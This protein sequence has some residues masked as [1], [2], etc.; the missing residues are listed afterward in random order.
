MKY[1]NDYSLPEALV[2]FVTD[3]EYSIGEADY[4]FSTVNSPPQ[5]RRLISIHNDEI[6]VDVS[7]NLWMLFGTAVH[8]LL[9]DADKKAM[10]DK[11]EINDDLKTLADF[12]T[13]KKQ[14]RLLEQRMYMSVGGVVISGQTDKY[15]PMLQ[16]IDDYKTTSVYKVMMDDKDDWE[17][18]MNVYTLLLEHNGHPVKEANIQAFLKDWKAYDYAKDKSG[19]YPPIPFKKETFKLWDRLDTLEFLIKRIRLHQSVEGIIDAKELYEKAPCTP[20]DR[21][22]N[23]PTEYRVFKDGATRATNNGVFTMKTGAKEA[24]DA[25]LTTKGAGYHI[26]KKLPESKRCIDCIVQPFCYQYN[27]VIKAKL[28]TDDSIETLTKKANSLFDEMVIETNEVNEVEK[29]IED[30]A[31]IFESV[32]DVLPTMQ[33]DPTALKDDLFA[34][35]MGAKEVIEEELT[36]TGSMLVET[37]VDGLEAILPEEVTDV[38]EINKIAEGLSEVT[39]TAKPKEEPQETTDADIDNLLGDLL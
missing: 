12:E 8:K 30:P 34:E 7:K 19:K 35:I 9:E 17:N 22:A 16:V 36:D 18:Q 1:T 39:A 29:V 28:E 2:R 24:A 5:I 15:N 23:K 31:S 11:I 38:V 14:Y 4:S 32:T 27:N 26:E 6:V 3:D 25:F 33:G 13:K 10:A 21:W 37:N 20:K